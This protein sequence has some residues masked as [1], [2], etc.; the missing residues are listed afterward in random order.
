MTN[1]N[2][3]KNVFTSAT[4]ALTNDFHAFSSLGVPKGSKSS[5]VQK[6]SLVKNVTSAIE[7]IESDDFGIRVLIVKTKQ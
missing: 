5:T 6:R 2:N 7:D 3:N 4:K 1:F